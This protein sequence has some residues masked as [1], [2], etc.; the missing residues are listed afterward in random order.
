MEKNHV[1]SYI[2]L[3]ARYKNS[4]FQDFESYPRT[5]VDLVEDD[6]SLVL[7][8]YN[9]SFITYE[10]PPGIYSF[11]DLSEVLPRDLRIDNNDASHSIT[12]EY[13]DITMKTKL[14]ANTKIIAISF[15]EKSFFSIILCFTLHWD[16]KHYIESV[17]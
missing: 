9:S 13:D 1:G 14:V 16:Y 15:H 5:E 12:I 3:L 4:I 10:I 17:K 2:N 6:I 7:D 8:E 11:K